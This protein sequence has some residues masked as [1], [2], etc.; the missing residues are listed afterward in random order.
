[1]VEWFCNGEF[2]WFVKAF[3]QH[4]V[5]FWMKKTSSQGILYCLLGPWTS[6]FA[7]VRL[8]YRTLEVARWCP[9]LQ[10]L[11]DISREG[12][13]SLISQCLM[14][15]DTNHIPCLSFNYSSC[16]HLFVFF[17]FLSSIYLSFLL[18]FYV[19]NPKNHI[20]SKKP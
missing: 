18:Q 11:K 8:S 3:C 13:W 4:F 7:L 9:S 20:L 1:M 12:R 16:I 15:W 2:S 19:K 5:N 17:L 6:S 10:V 14:D